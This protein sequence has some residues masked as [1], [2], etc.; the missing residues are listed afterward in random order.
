MTDIR[1]NPEQQQPTSV[2]LPRMR[3]APMNQERPGP[4]AGPAAYGAQARAGA[5]GYGGV[6]AC[7]SLG[8]HFFMTG[9]MHL[10]QRVLWD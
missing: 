4:V 2:S 1:G 10:A 7:R 9:A 3:L 6:L 8:P 5:G